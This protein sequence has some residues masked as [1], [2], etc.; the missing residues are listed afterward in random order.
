MLRMAD[1]GRAPAAS[2]MSGG[3]A[4]TCRVRVGEHEGVN[5]HASLDDGSL[6]AKVVEGDAALTAQL[7]PATSRA[8]ASQV[9]LFTVSAWDTN[10]EQH[11]PQ[12]YEAAEVHAALAE[13]DRRIAELERELAE[14]RQST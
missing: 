4:L 5:E 13:R 3:P 2:A 1:V 10:C 6:V 14:L 11:I 12:R 9:I 7:M 8:R